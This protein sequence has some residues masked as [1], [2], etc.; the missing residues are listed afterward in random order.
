MARDK[1]GVTY[2]KRNKGKYDYH[3]YLQVMLDRQGYKKKDVG[4]ILGL[5]P[6]NT[7]FV[8]NGAYKLTLKQAMTLSEHFGINIKLW[9]CKSAW[10]YLLIEPVLRIDEK[11]EI[12]MQ[13]EWD[14]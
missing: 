1:N 13:R 9:A 12:L 2:Y 14:A 11:R 5:S 4:T 3:L 10:I 6:C 7:S 8:M